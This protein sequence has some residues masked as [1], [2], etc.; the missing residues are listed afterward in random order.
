MGCGCRGRELATALVAEGHAVRGTTRSSE[1]LAEIEA[2]GA[3]AAVAE[4][5][6]LGSLL[7]LLEGV[8]AL[9]WLAPP[10]PERL[11]SLVDYL[12]D[13][14]VRGLICV[15]DPAA[16]ARRAGE[17]RSVPVETLEGD[18]GTPELLQDVRRLL[19]A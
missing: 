8:S 11:P 1:Q 19:G 2:T 16:A 5:D 14:P 18:S 4:P 13:T 12:V 3:E 6:R 7:P 17:R 15:G 10:E 9:V